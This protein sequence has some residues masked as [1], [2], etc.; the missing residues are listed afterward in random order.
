MM[1]SELSKI[2]VLRREI[3]KGFNALIPKGGNIIPILIRTRNEDKIRGVPVG[4]RV[5]AKCPLKEINTNRSIP[6]HTTK[7]N[8]NVSII[9]VVEGIVYKKKP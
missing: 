1:S 4:I 3:E 5:L 9:L 8:L 2:A 7:A 6:T